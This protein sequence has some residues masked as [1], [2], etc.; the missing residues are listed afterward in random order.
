MIAQLITQVAERV[1]IPES[2]A[3]QGVGVV[4]G[5]LLKQGDP[6]AVGDLFAQVPGAADLAAS[7][8]DAAGEAAGGPMGGLLGRVGG[9]LGG[10]AGDTMSALAA[11][12]KTGLTIDQGKAMLPVARDFLAQHADE[13]TVRRAL[14]SV[15]ALKGFVV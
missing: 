5:L 8:A 7:Y 12:Q 4:L 10:K 15:P 11:F 2:L 9:M 6:A 14:E 13:A 1:G 3:R